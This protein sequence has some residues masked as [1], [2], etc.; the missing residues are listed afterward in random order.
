MPKTSRSNRD[1]AW[2]ED[3]RGAMVLHAT[4]AALVTGVAQLSRAREIVRL[5]L[6]MTWAKAAIL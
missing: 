4:W 2:F 5:R 6:R 1:Y 3:Q